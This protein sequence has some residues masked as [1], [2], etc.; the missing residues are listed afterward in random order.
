MRARRRLR[1]RD[2]PAARAQ[3]ARQQVLRR[4][5]D[6]PRVD[7]LR[8]PRLHGLRAVQGRPARAAFR[9]RFRSLRLAWTRVPLQ[10]F[11]LVTG[12]PAP[13][14]VLPALALRL[15]PRPPRLLRPDTLLRARRPRVGAVHPQPALQLREPQLKAAFP[16]PRRVQPRPK[17]GHLASRSASRPLSRAFA[18][19]S[20]AASSGTGSSG[21]RRRLPH[22]ANAHQIDA[23]RTR[24]RNQRQE[25]KMP[26]LPCL[27]I[28]NGG[29]CRIRLTADA[30]RALCPEA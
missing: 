9:R 5:P 4:L 27:K 16:L 3:Q 14:P 1:E 29:G 22:P 20:P 10:A 17:R 12:L 24:R 23:R 11:P 26:A 19:R 25:G 21:M 2:H 18:A 7:D 8:P 28:F 6:D 15:L 13:L 30:Q